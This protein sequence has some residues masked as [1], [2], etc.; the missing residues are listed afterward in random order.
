MASVREETELGASPDEV[1]KLVGDFVGFVEAMGLSVESEG[2]GIGALRTI[3]SGPEPVVERLEERDEDAM[4]I[5]YSIVSGPLPVAN[6][7][8]T[9]ELAPAGEGRSA[10]IW[11]GTFEPAPGVT[12]EKAVSFVRAVYTSGI[13]GL[14]R[15]FGA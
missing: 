1:W 13:A 7:R 6:Y 4:R 14:H 11:T 5:V 3:S 10:L 8:S 9:I 15:R 2:H 12:E